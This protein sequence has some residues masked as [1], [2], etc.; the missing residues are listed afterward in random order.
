MLSLY[1]LALTL[2]AAQVVA[3]VGHKVYNNV[4]SSTSK[5]ESRTEVHLEKYGKASIKSPDPFSGEISDWT[6]WKVGTRSSLGLMGL[7]QVL[8]NRDYALKNTV[9]NTMVY[10][11]LC[12]AVVKGTASST[13]SRHNCLDDGNAA[14]NLLIERHEGAIQRE[15]EAKRVRA[16]LANLR[17]DLRT[18]GHECQNK[19]QEYVLSFEISFPQ[20]FNILGAIGNFQV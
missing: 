18:P 13:F 2:T 15:P 1:D 7:T 16:F 3:L 5:E 9:K 11:L 4:F 17:L 14:W 10:H 19:F 8:D 6:A 12:Q 20:S